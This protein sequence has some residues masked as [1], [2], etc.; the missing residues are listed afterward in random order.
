GGA[1]RRRRGLG[2]RAGGLA[3]GGSG[4]VHELAPEPPRGRP[5]EPSPDPRPKPG[6]GP[7]PARPG[8]LGP[9]P[10]QRPQSCV[11]RP[12]T[13]ARVGH[14]RPTG[15]DGPRRPDPPEVRGL[16]G[17]LPVGVARGSAAVG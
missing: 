5:D 10:S 4:P 17:S 16:P 14:G 9:P 11:S 7:G 3:R 8:P 1:P 2:D 13:T 15:S 12:S 6:R